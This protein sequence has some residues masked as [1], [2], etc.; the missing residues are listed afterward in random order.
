MVTSSS[1]SLALPAALLLFYEV[2][3]VPTRSR[4]FPAGRSLTFFSSPRSLRRAWYGSNTGVLLLNKQLLGV[5]SFGSPLALTV[6]HMA[7]CHLLCCACSAVGLVRIVRPA[8]RRQLLKVSALASVFA[9]S[10]ALGNASL[11]SIPVSFNQAIGAT[12]PFFTAIFSATLRNRCESFETYAALLPV[13]GGVVLASR[14]EPHFVLPGF[15][16]CV[17]ATASRALKSVLQDTLLSAA[18]GEELDSMSLLAYMSPVAIALLTPAS[19]HLE[20]GSLTSV[21]TLSRSDSNFLLL[22]SLNALAAFGAN[23]SNFL[24][25]RVTSALTLQVLGN[26]K[27]A[28]AAALSIFVFKN[29]VSMVWVGGYAITLAGLFWYSNAKLRATTLEATPAQHAES[30]QGKR[31]VDNG[32]EALR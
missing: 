26:A 27:G 32:H 28:F 8:S 22:I 16:A 25:T 17:F 10:V 11:R 3:S 21:Y 4:F 23:L 13:V 1:L 19:L 29:T 5:H 2:L 31:G 20:P 9:L 30:T 18:D 15:L 14:F 7:T 12:T 6:V 24:V